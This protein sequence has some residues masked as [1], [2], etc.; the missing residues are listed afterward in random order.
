MDCANHHDYPQGF[1]WPSDQILNILGT[2][3]F[4]FF[5]FINRVQ[6]ISYVKKLCMQKYTKV[7]SLTDIKWFIT[8]EKT[9]HNEDVLKN[10]TWRN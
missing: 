3:F 6:S 2:F 7:E 1:L 10:Q 4:F 8:D 9:H 5:Q